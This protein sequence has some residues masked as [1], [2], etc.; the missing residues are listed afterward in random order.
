MPIK[1]TDVV[2]WNSGDW[3]MRL[4]HARPSGGGAV[5]VAFCWCAN[6]SSD[7]PDY[8]D[9]GTA[10][11]VLKPIGGSAAPAKF[12]ESFMKS[13]IG[14]KTVNT[15]AVTR[16]TERAKF[17]AVLRAL[18]GFKAKLEASEQSD[19]SSNVTIQQV[20]PSRLYEGLR[21][22]PDTQRIRATKSSYAMSERDKKTL[23]RWLQ[24]WT[25]YEAA[26]A[27]LIQEVARD[28]IE[29]ADQYKDDNNK[30]AIQRMLGDRTLMVNL[31]RLFAVDA[32]LG[33][34]DRLC[35]VN[36][37]NILYTS[38]GEIWAIDSQTIL[39][40]YHAVVQTG[41][42]VADFSG[43]ENPQNFAQNLIGGGL[44]QVPT[45]PANQAQVLA[46]DFAMKWFYDLD[47]WY[48]VWFRYELESKIKQYGQ[49][50]PQEK[51]WQQAQVWFKSGV[52]Q[53]L[54][55][56]DQQLSGLNWLGAKSKFHKYAAKYGSDPNLD[57]TNFKLRR[58]YLK[59]VRA[60]PKDPDKAMSAV[61]AY[62]KKKLR[63]PDTSV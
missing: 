42:T 22:P 19:G 16:Q 37:G 12:A 35:Q 25:H 33:N 4:K 41:K 27:F 57:W 44:K 3:A 63:V 38:K 2:K 54:R 48:T 34:G 58:V 31:G 50:V 60:Y 24:V 47:K 13:A 11:F 23:A 62:A 39:Q 36:P 32:V 10:D 18:R 53:G 59:A 61:E 1:T 40:N 21:R 8:N 30:D 9:P 46:P 43:N 26:G 29:L 28:R 6:P 49:N 17:D 20:A 15:Q 55:E 51:D 5:G 56:V 52:E 7:G 45:G 14:A